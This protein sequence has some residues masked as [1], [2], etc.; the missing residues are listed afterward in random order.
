MKTITL[1]REMD[2]HLYY[3]VGGAMGAESPDQCRRADRLW[4]QLVAYS[5]PAAPAKAS[6]KYKLKPLA[7]NEIH[8]VQWDGT[9]SGARSIQTALHNLRT[10]VLMVDADG[11]TVTCWQIQGQGA[12]K[13]EVR[14]GDWIITD[15]RGEHYVCDPDNFADTYEPA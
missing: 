15:S 14:A 13:R 12:G 7:S 5:D 4:K 11:T 10:T 9:L 1:P 6:M 3:I 8:A 2:E